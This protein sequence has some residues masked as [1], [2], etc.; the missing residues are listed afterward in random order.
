MPKGAAVFLA[1]I[2]GGGPGR[3]PSSCSRA[4]SDSSSDCFWET[5]SITRVAPHPASPAIAASFASVV[6]D[7]S[8][9]CAPLSPRS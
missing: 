6:I 3:T 9:L 2:S 4:C 5:G 7:R 8:W 1:V